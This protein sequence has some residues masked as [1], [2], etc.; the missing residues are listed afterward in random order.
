MKKFGMMLFL[1][2]LIFGSFADVKESDLYY[3]QAPIVRAFMHRKGYYIIYRTSTK[4]LSEVYIPFSWF[5][6]GDGR[7]HL[8][9]STGRTTPYLSLFT[10]DGTFHHINIVLPVENPRDAVWG[11]LKNPGAYDDKFNVETV[12]FQ[13]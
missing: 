4:N 3:V 7:A 12:E 6:P 1:L 5:K 10:K 13:Y 2:T 9:N 11:L 8:K